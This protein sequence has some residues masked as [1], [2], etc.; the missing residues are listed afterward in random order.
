M[1]RR[2]Q[3]SRAVFGRMLSLLIAPLLFISVGYALLAQDLSIASEVDNVAY[4]A[5]QGLALSYEVS[6]YQKGNKYNYNFVVTIANH[7]NSE[8]SAWQALF[9][10]PADA[11]PECVTAVCSVENG[12]VTV[13]NLPSNGTLVPGGSTSFSVSFDS[14]QAD[15]MLQNI[16]VS[17]FV[18]QA[19][20]QS[21]DGLTVSAVAGPQIKVKQYYYRDYAITVTN[22]SGRDLAGWRVATSWPVSNQVGE[23]TGFVNYIT[24]GGRL[25]FSSSSGL[26]KGQSFGFSARLGSR[27][28]SWSPGFSVEGR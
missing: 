23:V 5:T 17:G 15:Y 8:V 13:N 22:N 25:L 1:S 7:G 21:M 9:D 28:T 6:S 20:Y 16:R 19:S 4:V 18:T 11:T 27:V 14:K 10:I 3:K 24:S 26:L 12:T 2:R